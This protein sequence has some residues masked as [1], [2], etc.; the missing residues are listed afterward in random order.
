MRQTSGVKADDLSPAVAAELP[1]TPVD[2]AASEVS[3]VR[4]V[5]GEHDGAAAL[6]QPL[7]ELP[8]DCLNT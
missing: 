2:D 7:R 5:V 8:V 6:R 1:N 4:L 3:L